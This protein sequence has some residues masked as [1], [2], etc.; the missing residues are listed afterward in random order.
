MKAESAIVA[1][2]QAPGVGRLALRDFDPVADCALAHTWL[3]DPH[4]HYWGMQDN[5]PSDTQEY[6]AKI[7]ASAT[8]NAWLGLHYERPVFLVERYAPGADVIGRFYDVAAGDLGMH[9]LI[10]PP[11]QPI[12]GFTW[13]VFSFVVDT[14]FAVDAP[15]RLVVEPD[16]ANT[17]IQRLNARAGFEVVADI[18]IGDKIARLSMLSRARHDAL[19][20]SA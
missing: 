10:A 5:T 2:R 18:D 3:T 17:A 15:A 19:R 7:A 9:I 8:H 11:T 12:H 13:A 1:Q 14:I 6:F 16:A 4:A 20:A